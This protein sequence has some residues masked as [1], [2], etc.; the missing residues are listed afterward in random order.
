MDEK[1]PEIE[2]FLKGFRALMGFDT[3]PDTYDAFR[4]HLE[5][6]LN[7]TGGQYSLPQFV[8]RNPKYMEGSMPQL[9]GG[10]DNLTEDGANMDA[11]LKLMLGLDPLTRFKVA[12]DGAL[13]GA[14]GMII[15]NEERDTFLLA[16]KGDPYNSG[17]IGILGG[18]GSDK[19]RANAM[20]MLMRELVEEI[21]KSILAKSK[22][23]EILTTE[24]WRETDTR[25]VYGIWARFFVRLVN[26][27]EEADIIRG[28]EGFQTKLNLK[29]HEIRKLHA[30]TRR[31]VLE[32]IR[33]G[34][35]G[36]YD[37]TAAFVLV[38]MIIGQMGLMAKQFNGWN[39]LKES[40]RW[41]MTKALV[42]DAFQDATDL[43]K[44]DWRT[45]IDFT[46]M[47]YG[48]KP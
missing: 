7:I 14:A 38:N 19:D 20:T 37:Q 9:W 13:Q 33:N 36:Y 35:M 27:E 1:S 3:H 44:G 17:K 48:L 47:I 32:N 43:S 23:F 2:A 5:R 10:P 8:Q 6:A 30:Y 41:L 24:E 45:N 28:F 21:G 18:Q 34:R 42:I 15:Y 40:Q 46:D 39:L 31:E 22:P 4:R 16:V 12:L 29:D 11:I 26:N 25:G